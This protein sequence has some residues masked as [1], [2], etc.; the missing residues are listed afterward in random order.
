LSEQE[1]VFSFQI[2]DD[3]TSI[4][5]E[6]SP[7]FTKVTFEELL[8]SFQATITGYTVNFTVNEQ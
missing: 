7:L 1:H 4:T 2:N 6:T 5:M 3:N 8:N